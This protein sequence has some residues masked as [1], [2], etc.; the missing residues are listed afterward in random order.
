MTFEDE[1]REH[2]VN[3]A[4]SWASQEVMK[5]ID[6]YDVALQFVLEELDAA[7]QGND[8]AINYAKN[9]GF[10]EN[11][12]VDA[13]GNSFEEVDGPDGP[14]Q[15]LLTQ[16]MSVSSMDTKVKLRVTIVDKVMQEWKLGKYS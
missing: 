7:R 5:R 2:G 11:E 9:S 1:V 4:A 14:Q 10:K 3:S 12:Y 15:M 6:S 8:T 16:I 13:M